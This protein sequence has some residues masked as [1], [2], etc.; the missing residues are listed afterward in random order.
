MATELAQP[1]PWYAFIFLSFHEMHEK[2]ILPVFCLK[3][4]CPC[5]RCKVNAPRFPSRLFWQCWC[6]TL[7]HNRGSYK[8]IYPLHIW[9]STANMSRISSKEVLSRQC[10]FKVLLCNFSLSLIHF[11]YL[12]CSFLSPLCLDY[13]CES[14]LIKLWDLCLA[15]MK[16]EQ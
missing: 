12:P 13:T 1:A 3:S 9:F 6:Y 5:M 4:Y 15:L 11:Q 2:L 7:K 14:E 8:N 10:P 16:G